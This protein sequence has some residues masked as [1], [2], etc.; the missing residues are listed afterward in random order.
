MS[1]HQ[2][3]YK[4]T[5]TGAV[6][7]WSV[8]V[9]TVDSNKSLI[10]K[11]A[12]Q[13]GGKL[14]HHEEPILEGKN[15][16]RYNRTTP[17]EQ[18]KS[19]ALSDWTRKHDEGYKTIQDIMGWDTD[20]SAGLDASTI[21]TM[22]D[23]Y[24]PQFN[25]D[26]SGQAKPML[27]KDVN[28]AKVIFPCYIQPKLDGVRCLM[29]VDNLG[30]VK[31]LSRSGKDY[32]TLDHIKNSIKLA[33][34][35]GGLKL[36]FILDGEIYSDELSF[37]DIVASVKKKRHTTALLKFRCY[38]IITDSTQEV[39]IKEFQAMVKQIASQNIT[40]VETHVVSTKEEVM[41]YHDE[42]VQKD[43]EGLMIRLPKG[44]YAS[45]QRST[46]LVKVKEFQTTEYELTGYELGQREEDLIAVCNSASGEFRA[47][48]Q[49]NAKHKEELQNEWNNSVSKGT[50]QLTV[51]HF[52][53]TDSGLPRFPIGITVRDY[54]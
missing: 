12:G 4:R 48:M 22:L 13:F 21:K 18:A 19:Q 17:E 2:T 6:Q 14:V 29:I 39:R 9:E 36:P 40:A 23:A 46:D 7:Q 31:F 1:T 52:G 16:G 42:F 35:R 43:Q 38:D 47:K 28:W 33:I 8:R 51:K 49:G 30:D 41:K 32:T 15:L 54:E 44:T 50:A 5:K 24:L 26:A 11:D 3:L 34:N 25:T 53:L 10:V 27:A 20:I 45:G 37:Q